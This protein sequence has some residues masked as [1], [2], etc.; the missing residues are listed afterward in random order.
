M[1]KKIKVEKN[2]VQET[3]VLPLFGKA[4]AVRNYP[5]IFKDQDVQGIMD[6]VDYDFSVMEKA[7]SGVKGKIGSLA[8]AT[9]QAA[10]VWEIKDYLKDHP[11]ALVVN[12]GC[13]LDTAG[14]QADNGTCRFANV[15]FPNVIELREQLI[16]ST[17]REKNIASDLNDLSWFDKIDFDAEEGVV[18]IASGVFL[19]FKKEDVKKLFCAMAERF[20]GGR[21]AF[22][23]QNQKGKD[24]D[25]KALKASGI[26]I[27]TNFALDD[28]ENE[29]KSWSDRFA[30]VQWKKM[31][32][33]YI[34]PDK[35]FGILY[36]IMAPIADK[37]GMSQLDV[38][39][40]KM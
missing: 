19:Y 20:P 16:P 9:R 34:K 2:S 25:L 13:G 33:G 23:G 27:S 21:I 31:S 1:N 10:L 17:D 39:D 28:P 11:S 24:L 3:L 18:F 15:D 32:T 7:A 26:D 4:W 8:A 36:R 38:I 14:H 30:R 22:D 5:D 35:R 29:L 6:Q 12:L 37:N 40:F